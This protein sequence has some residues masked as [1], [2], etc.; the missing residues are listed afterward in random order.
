[1]DWGNAIVQT[2]SK[3]AD[4]K[5]ITGMHLFCASACIH[6]GF[7]FPMTAG[8]NCVSCLI[9]VWHQHLCWCGLVPESFL[10]CL[11]GA[12]VKAVVRLMSFAHYAFYFDK[13]ATFALYSNH[14]QPALHVFCIQRHCPVI[15]GAEGKLHLEG[16]VKTTKW[17]LHWL[18]NISELVPL[19]LVDFDH[20]ITKKK[21]EEGDAIEDNV[22]KKSVRQI[23]RC[24]V[25]FWPVQSGL[26]NLLICMIGFNL[27]DQYCYYCHE[28]YFMI[29][30]VVIIT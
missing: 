2:I 1:M 14:Q 16:S 20:L 29:I 18:P 25:P 7:F 5:T 6:M 17:K 21:L 9:R 8:S 13:Q 15:S 19:R 24:K 12:I 11:V 22:N 23:C 4:G 28:F 27:H 26:V 30:N 3:S 10:Q